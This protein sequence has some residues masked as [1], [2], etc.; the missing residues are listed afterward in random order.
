[1][2]LI[3]RPMMGGGGGGGGGGEVFPGRLSILINV[4][5]LSCLFFATVACRI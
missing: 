2:V 4:V 1:M 3:W 5:S